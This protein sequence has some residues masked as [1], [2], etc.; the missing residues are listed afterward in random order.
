MGTSHKKAVQADGP[1]QAVITLP[2]FMALP[3]FPSIHFPPAQPMA[4]RIRPFPPSR[5]SRGFAKGAISPGRCPISWTRRPP[6]AWAFEGAP[7][8]GQ[9][10]AICG[11]T[12][13]HVE[14]F[15]GRRGQHPPAAHDRRQTNAVLHGFHA[16]PAGRDRRGAVAAAMKP[17][18]PD[19]R[20]WYEVSRDPPTAADMDEWRCALCWHIH[21]GVMLQGLDNILHCRYIT[22]W[23]PTPAPPEAYDGPEALEGVQPGP[24]QALA[25]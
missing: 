2:V 12:V 19:A 24:A 16:V 23:R 22:H 11:A 15:S 20:G 8:G 25:R 5:A 10:R 21:Q 17:R 3:T 1:G 9:R 13:G 4:V 18:T 6:A 14:G 7:A